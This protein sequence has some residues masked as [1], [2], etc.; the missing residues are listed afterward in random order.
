M[1]SNSFPKYLFKCSK[2]K[3][4]KLL[5]EIQ[6]KLDVQ[7]TK[8]LQIKED[9]NSSKDHVSYLNSFR[10]DV[11]RRIFNL[12]DQ[13]TM[14][15]ET[16]DNMK[17]VF[18][19]LNIETNQYKLLGLRRDVNE[20]ST[21]VFNT[22]F[23]EMKSKL[24]SCEKENKYL[25]DKKNLKGKGKINEVPKWILDA[26]TKSK[27]GLGYVKNN[28]K[29]KV[30]VDLPSSKICSFCGK[31]GHLKYQCVKREQ[32]T[33]ANKTYVECLWIKKYDSCIID[34]EPKDDWVTEPNH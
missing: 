8:N 29:K 26:K 25:K 22:E 12:I 5:L 27:E 31:N 24:E 18:I 9:L 6:E 1:S 10:I 14:L 4:I 16:L 32:H 17:Q 33:K 20:I 13:N 7:N 30:Y 3:L 21:H 28:R 2:N 34:R 15:R 11:R 23:Q 19:I